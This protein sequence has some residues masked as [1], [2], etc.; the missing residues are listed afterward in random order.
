MG[1]SKADSRR[2]KSSPGWRETKQKHSVKRR[3]KQKAATEKRRQTLAEMKEQI[4]RELREEGIDVSKLDVTT[5]SGVM[6]KA[7][8]DDAR[9]S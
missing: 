1:K 6:I 7:E 2:Y 4:I 5:Q 9:S 8:Y 3:R